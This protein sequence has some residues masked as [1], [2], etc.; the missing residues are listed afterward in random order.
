MR[1]QST[2]SWIS[3]IYCSRCVVR[4][5][6]ELSGLQREAR[7]VDGERAL[8]VAHVVERRE[9]RALQ[10]AHAQLAQQLVREVRARDARLRRAPARAPGV[11][12]VQSC[13]SRAT[14]KD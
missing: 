13:T 2:C 14:N 3:W 9:T 8:D 6:D 7:V 5:A 12:I 1:A 4:L 11:A 10:V